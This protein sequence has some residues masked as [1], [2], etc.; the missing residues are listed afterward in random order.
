MDQLALHCLAQSSSSCQ[1]MQQC[2]TEKQN[3]QL[4]CSVTL[5]IKQAVLFP[6]KLIFYIIMNLIIKMVKTVIKLVETGDM[7]PLSQEFLKQFG[8]VSK[9]HLPSD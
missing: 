1:L 5:K 7:N 3:P 6:F 9:L 4:H 2:I 8:S